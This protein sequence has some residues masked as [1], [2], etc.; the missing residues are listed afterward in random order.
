MSESNESSPPAVMRRLNEIWVFALAAL[1]I[2]GGVFT[3]LWWMHTTDT[4]HALKHDRIKDRVAHVEAANTVTAQ[5]IDDLTLDIRGIM[6]AVGAERATRE[7]LHSTPTHPQQSRSMS[8][9]PE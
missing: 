9:A 6:I 2:I 4:A 7:A 1:P 3:L 8:P 5:K